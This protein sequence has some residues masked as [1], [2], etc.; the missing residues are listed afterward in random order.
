MAKDSLEEKENLKPGAEA[1]ESEEI[2][3][4]QEKAPSNGS[5]E[6][7]ESALE[8][9]EENIQEKL[10]S[11][12]SEA[13]DKYLRL[14]S[15]FENFRRRTARERLDLIKTANEDLVVSLLPIL[16]DFERAFKSSEGEESDGKQLRKGF[17]LIANKF[18]SILEQKGLKIMD[19]AAGK[20]FDP[21]TQEAVTQIPA[22][23]KKLKGKI[24]DVI[25]KGYYLE[26]KVIRFAKVV[27]GA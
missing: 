13:K 26:D 5:E 27:I 2:S 19:T 4:N 10:E 16:D 3:D 15:E 6:A 24:V 20:D 25:E 17:E 12:L 14:Y 23:E 21:D 7:A 22:P 18:R 9:A 11:E 1:T 8:D